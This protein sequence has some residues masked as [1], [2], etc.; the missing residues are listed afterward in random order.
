MIQEGTRLKVVDNTGAK[1]IQCFKILG[2]SRHRY[3]RIGNIVV[4]SI[5]K[6]EPRKIVKKKDIVRA[7]IIRQKK[8]Y[9]LP[10]GMYL[11]FDDNAAVI[12]EG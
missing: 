5:K 9:R 11:R 6:V 10:N 8:P 3:A 2:G 4:A 7:V 12:L 1:V